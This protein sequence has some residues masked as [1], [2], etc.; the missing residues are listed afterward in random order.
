MNL[1]VSC[2][3][4]SENSASVANMFHLL[5]N[6][7]ISKSKPFVNKCNRVD[8]QNCNLNYTNRP[9]KLDLSLTRSSRNQKIEYPFG[10][11]TEHHDHNIPELG[12][13]LKKKRACFIIDVTV[14]LA[15][16]TS[17]KIFRVTVPWRTI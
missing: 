13:L 4:L 8:I 9:Q 12:M 2:M 7:N 15:R 11:L 17:K 6:D 1:G 14:L 16:N 3:L 10:L 5:S